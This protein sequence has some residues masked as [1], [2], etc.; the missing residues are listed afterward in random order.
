MVFKECGAT[1][2][3][4]LA[5]PAAAVAAG[6]PVMRTDVQFNIVV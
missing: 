5:S 1:D 4:S 2:G 6:V 3:R